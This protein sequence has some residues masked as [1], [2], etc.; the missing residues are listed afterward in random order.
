MLT[1]RT[2][3]STLSAAST[4]LS[5][6]WSTLSSCALMRSTLPPTF[7]ITGS[8]SRSVPLIRSVTLSVVRAIRTNR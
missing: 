2:A 3:V 5:V 4:A 1:A 6:T 8:T 7:S